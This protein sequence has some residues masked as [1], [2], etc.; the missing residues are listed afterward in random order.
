MLISLSSQEAPTLS[1]TFQAFK[2][3]SLFRST[4][5][6]QAIVFVMLQNQN[7]PAGIQW[8]N[9]K[10]RLL[11]SDWFANCELC[12]CSL[13]SWLVYIQAWINSGEWKGHICVYDR[14]FLNNLHKKHTNVCSLKHSLY[15]VVLYIYI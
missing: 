9:S 7:E 10:L 4:E 8:A 6:W 15:L 12:F 14:A 1:Y 13:P 3:S 2:S 11:I 5:W